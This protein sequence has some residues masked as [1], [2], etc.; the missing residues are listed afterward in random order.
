MLGH[1]EFQLKLKKMLNLGNLVSKLS[2][3]VLKQR[4][5]LAKL[6]KFEYHYLSFSLFNK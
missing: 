3:V 6:V 2:P 5:S 4:V 1:T